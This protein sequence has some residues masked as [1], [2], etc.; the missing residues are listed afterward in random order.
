MAKIKRMKI[1]C[2]KL[3]KPVAKGLTKHLQ[4]SVG[5]IECETG[6]I[7][8]NL[9]TMYFFVLEKLTKKQE[10][11]LSD[12]YTFS[13]SGGLQETVWYTPYTIDGV[14]ASDGSF[15]VMPEKSFIEKVDP[16]SKLL[17]TIT[18]DSILS[19]FFKKEINKGTIEEEIIDEEIVEEEI[20]TTLILEPEDFTM[21]TT[22]EEVLPPDIDINVEEDEDDIRERI[23]EL[24]RENYRL[25]CKLNNTIE[26]VKNI[27]IWEVIF[28][29]W[30]KKLLDILEM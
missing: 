2:Y 12:G 26:E 21:T 5:R 20:E 15:L 14:N 27:T 19:L 24:E 1:F 30:K 11:H 3:S 8:E 16:E 6:F 9:G 22:Q 4:D 13:Y 17:E 25:S 29:K 28:W 10:I 7:K 18:L 23:K